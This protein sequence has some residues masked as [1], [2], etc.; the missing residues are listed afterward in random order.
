MPIAKWLILRAREQSDATLNRAGS[1]P[2]AGAAGL[3]APNPRVP[4]GYPGLPCDWLF[5]VAVEPVIII[6]AATNH[7]V[8]ANPAAAQLLRRSHSALVGAAVEGLLDASSTADL[9][10][11]LEV[12]RTAGVVDGVTLR[13]AG[14]GAELRAKLSLFRSDTGAYVLIH[15]ALGSGVGGDQPSADRDPAESP[16]LDAI[17][18]AAVGF[19]LTD[20]GMR[21]E[22]ANQAFTELIQLGSADQA[23]GK[24]LLRWLELSESDLAQLRDQMLL[25]RATSVM[26]AA[27]RI[28]SNSRLEVEVCAVAVPDGANTC[29]GFTIRELP[30]LN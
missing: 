12:A 6:D 28:E 4:T 7:I 2:D 16:V 23:L 1:D 18:G 17:E 25:R 27:L 11:S 13:S 26:T 24:S 9:A 29:W 10:R 14:D 3:R 20:S 22:Y 21:I 19:L 15:L 8:Q 5:S 30:R